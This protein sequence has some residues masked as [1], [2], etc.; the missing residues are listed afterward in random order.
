MVRKYLDMAA[1]VANGGNS[2]HEH[3]LGCTPEEFVVHM[4]STIAGG[5]Q[6]GTLMPRLYRPIDKAHRDDINHIE[7]A[8]HYTNIYAV[9]KEAHLPGGYRRRNI[10][11]TVEDARAMASSYL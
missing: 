7:A 2:K 9:L 6:G 11:R 1:K 3:L 8:F 5:Y 10:P 4:Q